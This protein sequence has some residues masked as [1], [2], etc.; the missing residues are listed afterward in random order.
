MN[1]NINKLKIGQV[2][3]T[4]VL[5]SF[6]APIIFLVFKIITTTNEIDL[7]STERVRSDYVL[8]LI[9]CILGIIGMALPGIASKKFKL[10]IPNNMY[11]LYIIFLYSAIFLGE[12]RNFY[13]DIPYWDIILHAFSGVMIGCI[14]FSIISLLNDKE[15]FHLNL[16]PFF[17]A[18][19]A[20][21][22]AMMLGTVWEI[23]E[24]SSDTILK[25]NMQK[26][27]L[28]NGSELVGREALK[29]T[30]DDLIVDGMGA[31]VISSIGYI[32][33]KKQT[34]WIKKFL[35]KKKKE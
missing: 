5:I 24:Y 12:I 2:F 32:S 34:G 10:E 11:Y 23:Y 8:M 26:Y 18:F 3:S 31:F 19:F 15:I 27:K 30:M 14:G 21:C 6:I 35:I 9:Q 22:F 16:T 28:E 4:C 20:F 33:L 7:E 13:Y 29:D 25:T 17:I 1:K